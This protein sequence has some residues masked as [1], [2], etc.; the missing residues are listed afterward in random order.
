MLLSLQWV[1]YKMKKTT[2]GTT[3]FGFNAAQPAM[4]LVFGNYGV[5]WIDASSFNAAQPA[6]GLVQIK[7]EREN[8]SRGRVSM[9]L[10]LQWVQYRDNIKAKINVL[11]SFNAAQPAM[12][13]V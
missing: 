11:I 6:M 13:L 7:Y 8:A 12:G 3:Y 4:G 9:L 10:S 5:E 1:Q 2:E